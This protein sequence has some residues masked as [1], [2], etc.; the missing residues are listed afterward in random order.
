MGSDHLTDERLLKAAYGVAVT[1]DEQHLAACRQ[2]AEH[3]ARLA[4][5][6]ESAAQHSFE[7]LPEG[8]WLRQRAA[9]RRAVSEAAL[10][11]APR[12]AFALAMALLLAVGV[13]LL[14]PWSSLW[15]VPSQKFVL[16]AE[17][18]RM[19]RQV[20]Q[21]ASRIEPRA[22]Q[23]ISLLLPSDAETTPTLPVQD[24]G[25]TLVVSA[26]NRGAVFSLV[27]TDTRR[28]PARRN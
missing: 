4:L 27:V 21:T 10:P 20:Y 28:A 17:D 2:C 14:G 16:Q 12:P 6:R 13:W 24:T 26:G 18:E 1:A 23:P 25:A 9:V 11:G 5:A 7:A 3:V 19:L 22:L 15:R 8:F